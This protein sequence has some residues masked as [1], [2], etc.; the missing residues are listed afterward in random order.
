MERSE[1]ASDHSL[2]PG[3]KLGAYAPGRVRRPN[4]LSTDFLKTGGLLLI[5]AMLGAGFAVGALV[6]RS[7]VNHKAAATA[8]L[9]QSFVAALAGDLERSGSFS[10]ASI[11]RLNTLMSSSP[12]Q[13]RFPYLEIWLPDGTI[14]YSNSA[15]LIGR[16]FKPPPSLPQAFAGD[17]ADYTD[18]RAAEHTSRHFGI[19]YLEIYSP[20][21]SGSTDAV[22]AVAEIHERTQPLDA[23]LERLRIG[24]WLVVAAITLLILGGL[25]GIV[26]RGTR[27]IELQHVAITDRIAEAERLAA[28]N[29]NLSDRLQRASVRSSEIH[30]RT[31][32][33]VGAELH[34]GP[35]QLI[36]FAKINLDEFL[37]ADEAH[38]PRLGHRIGAALDEAILEIR[39]ISAGLILPELRDVALDEV[40]RR[41]VS[42]HVQRTG[43]DVALDVS[44]IG[45]NVSEAVKICAF[46]FVQ[47]GLNNATRHGG[48][49]EQHVSCGLVGNVL[50]IRVSNRGTAEAPEAAP[51]G[52][53]QLGLLGLRERIESLGGAFSLAIEAGEAT[54]S[55][56][57]ELRGG[58]LEPE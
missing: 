52:R 49:P 2:Q 53:P 51:P 1:M 19:R 18:L 44:P 3:S 11:E 16:K 38:R 14:A 30:E 33:T 39:S 27:T 21:R 29:Q 40:V 17:I 7:T 12:L 54:L 46:R 56:T 58:L 4:Q 37:I 10:Q 5:L 41:A 34:D 35:A 8:I 45:R 50:T 32:R 57:V 13:E 26:R 20:I 55:M 23:D 6:K 15:A 47:E 36:G 28:Q 25:Y 48:G 24:S 9:V 43:A 22:V 42:K 31:L